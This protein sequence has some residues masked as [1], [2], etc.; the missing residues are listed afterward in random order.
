MS[1]TVDCRAITDTTRP[2]SPLPLTMF[3]STRTPSRLPASMRTVL[4]KPWFDPMATTRA[5]TSLNCAVPACS[6]SASSSLRRRSSPDAVCSRARSSAF[7]ASSS[8]MR[9][10]RD[11]NCCQSVMK[12]P[13]GAVAPLTASCTGVMTAPATGRRNRVSPS[14]L[15]MS[16][17]SNASAHSPRSATC[18]LWSTPVGR[19]AILFSCAPRPRTHAKA[20]RSPRCTFRIRARRSRAECRRSRSAFRFPGEGAHRGRAA[21]RRHR[22]ARCRDP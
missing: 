8:A 21:A 4:P 6:R 11:P 9:S 22:R 16:A 14:R 19:R 17:S 15:S 3:M 2:T 13:I 5:T 20:N 12:E 18:P 7:A 10:L 1:A